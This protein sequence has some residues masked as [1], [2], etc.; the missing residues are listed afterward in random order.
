[1]S[2]D[3]AHYA[4]LLDISKQIQSRQMSSV[5]ATQAQLKRIEQLDGSLKSYATDWHRHHPQV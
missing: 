1:M 4:E 3:Q 5:E 2:Q